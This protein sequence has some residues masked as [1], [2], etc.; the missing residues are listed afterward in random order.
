MIFKEYGTDHTLTIMLL[1]GGGLS[2]W[3]YREEAELLQSE[4]HVILPILD[5][6]AGSDR[7]FTSIENNASEII[8]FIEQNYN[9]KVSFI[10]GLSLGAQVLLEILSQKNDIC[11][12][13]L[14]ESAAVIP[15]KLTHALIGPSFNASYGLIQNRQF[16]KMQFKSL[17]IKED[18]FE[19]YYHDTCLIKKQD[20]INFMKENTAYALKDSLQTC[21]AKVHI[22][23]GEKENK[24]IR[25]SAMEIQKKLGSSVIHPLS[26]LYHGE[27]S[28]N[29][30]DAYADAVREIIH[31]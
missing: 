31:A 19:D 5:G 21:K 12:Y 30:A 10:G 4:Y 27:F 16:A 18:L 15:S 6:H 3:N 22:Y 20:M 8:A 14:I 7:P 13:A 28:L 26:G 9:G 29:H 1:H 25:L 2:W 11:D 24:E 17:H 23:H